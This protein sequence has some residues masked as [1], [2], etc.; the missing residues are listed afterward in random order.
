MAFVSVL[1]LRK[2]GPKSKGP[3]IKFRKT[4]SHSGGGY[5]S[6]VIPLRGKRMQ[7][8]IDDEL[9]K[10]RISESNSGVSVAASGTFSCPIG[11]YKI[12]GGN[13]INLELSEDGWWYGSYAGTDIR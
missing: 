7:I 11:V 3:S 1:D 6:S 12:V 2:T 5:V 8:E 9:K 10:I 4:M 13:K